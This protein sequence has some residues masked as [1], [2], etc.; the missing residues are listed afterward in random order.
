M[1]NSNIKISISENIE[2]EIKREV[3]E[4]WEHVEMY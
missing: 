2:R 4:S 3:G 1:Q